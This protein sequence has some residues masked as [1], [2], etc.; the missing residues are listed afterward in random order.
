MR[1]MRYLAVSVILLG[2][3]TKPHPP[4]TGLTT[5]DVCNVVAFGASPDDAVADT[6]ALQAAIDACAGAGGRVVVPAG[7]FDTGMLTLGSDMILD[8]NEGAILRL[9]PDI[10]LFPEIVVPRPG[11]NADRFRTAFY[12]PGVTGLSI[13]GTGAID[14]NGPDFWDDNYYQSGLR[15]PTLPRPQP[16]IEISDCKN[17]SVT[18]LTLR[19]LPAAALRLHR[20][21]DTHVQDLT[22][23]NDPR[24]PNTDGIQVRDSS[25][26]LIEGV[27]ISTGDDAIVLKSDER[28]VENVRVRSSVLESD[29]SG[30]RFGTGSAVGVR[31]SVF[32]DIEIRRSRYGIAI[33]MIDGGRH[34]NN[35][36]ENIS[37]STGSRHARDYAVFVDID[38]RTADRS[39][40]EIDNL[41][42]RNVSVTTD[43]NILIAGSP[44]SS[45]GTL[46]L[47][48][49]RMKLVSPLIDLERAASKPRGNINIESQ[50][51]SVDYSG[52]L[53]TVTIAHVQQLNVDGLVLD[54]AA[55]S[56]RA[57]VVLI[58]AHPSVWKGVESFTEGTPRKMRL[59]M[60]GEGE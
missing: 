40:G 9:I 18:G 22:I 14:G 2:A 42:F 7:A 8:L 59:N 55:N 41:T 24:S 28:I 3:C 48:G 56:M 35:L 32:S 37:I 12:A 51:G 36:F 45:L 44:E 17:V 50:A 58:D 4:A 27:R 33:F 34:D 10:A 5:H 1:Q 13:V 54:D 30:I 43:A 19:N 20:C 16:V 46:N 29:D 26:V 53:A 47:S 23:W 11:A 25:N 31:N 6:A 57:D 15:R 39:L 52:E 49:V 60:R 38:R 21:T